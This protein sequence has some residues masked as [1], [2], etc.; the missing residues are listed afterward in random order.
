MK[1]IFKNG[2]ISIKSLNNPGTGNVGMAVI[3]TLQKQN[4]SLEIIVRV[5]DLEDAGKKLAAYKVSF[6]NF[7]FTNSSTY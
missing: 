1:K 6:E 5:K 2:N 7:N 3:K 4:H